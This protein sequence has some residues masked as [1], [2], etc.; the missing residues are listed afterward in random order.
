MEIEIIRSNES[1]SSAI[2][3]A[4]QF[5]A[6]LDPHDFAEWKGGGITV[7][8]SSSVPVIRRIF[9]LFANLTLDDIRALTDSNR[10]TVSN[11]LRRVQEQ[12]HKINNQI[13]QNVQSDQVLNEFKGIYEGNRS[14]LTHI[15]AYIRPEL[16]DERLRTMF[17]EAST[18]AKELGNLV[19]RAQQMFTHLQDVSA[20]AGVARHAV[21]FSNASE[22][23]AAAKSLWLKIT[24]GLGVCAAENRSGYLSG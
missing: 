9:D 5:V 8:L 10:H 3:K 2:W 17:D 1:N 14:Q 7:D 23:H 4:C 22:R 16:A 12:L 24:V 21:T 13:P 6:G 11:E 20:Q 19:D 18:R 15:L